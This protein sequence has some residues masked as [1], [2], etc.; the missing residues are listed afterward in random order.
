MDKKMRRV[1][2]LLR[3]DQYQKIQGLGLNLSGLIRD[4][5]DDRLSHKK[6]IFSV[7]PETR[8]IYDHIVSNLGGSDG[9][10]E[11]CFLKALDEL[12]IQKSVDISKA[13]DRLKQTPKN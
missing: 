10:L 2:V 11:S 9:E 4:T 3:E 8:A 1:N 6:I 12:L 13:R 5:I 7:T